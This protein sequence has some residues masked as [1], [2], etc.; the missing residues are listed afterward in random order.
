MLSSWRCIWPFEN[1]DDGN[2]ARQQG[3][4]SRGT[5]IRSKLAEEHSPRVI[6]SRM[7]NNLKVPSMLH[8][9]FWYPAFSRDYFQSDGSKG[10][11]YKSC[12]MAVGGGGVC[13]RLAGETR[14]WSITSSVDVPPMRKCHAYAKS[15]NGDWRMITMIGDII[16]WQS[17]LRRIEECCRYLAHKKVVL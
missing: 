1:F 8:V 13:R 7:H 5:Q 17:A 3:V 12:Q 2:L 11:G 14:R 6:S 16:M 9:K 4:E 15:E 10:D